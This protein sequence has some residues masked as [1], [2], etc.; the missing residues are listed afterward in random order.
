MAEGGIVSIDWTHENIWVDFRASANCWSAVQTMTSVQGRTAEWLAQAVGIV[1]TLSSTEQNCRCVFYCSSSCHRSGEQG[2]ANRWRFVQEKFLISDQGGNSKAHDSGNVIAKNRS[3]HEHASGLK[4]L[5]L[6]RESA[7][8][9]N[10]LL[11]AS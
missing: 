10:R 3:R 9:G 2:H 6:H 5:L 4:L 7:S 8:L 11:V 1:R